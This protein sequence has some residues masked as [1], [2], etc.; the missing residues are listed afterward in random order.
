MKKLYVVDNWSVWGE[1]EYFKDAL[2]QAFECFN[3]NG[4]FVYID[5]YTWEDEDITWKCEY[6]EILFYHPKKTDWNLFKDEYEDYW[7]EFRNVCT[8]DEN[9]DIEKADK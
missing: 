4:W 7:I 2:D 6:W 5:E 3:N 8:I 9:M 1:R